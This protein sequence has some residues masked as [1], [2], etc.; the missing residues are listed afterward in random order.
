MTRAPRGLIVQGVA[1]LLALALLTLAGPRP[2][3][4]GHALTALDPVEVYIDGFGD[5]R[6][7]AVDPAG[8]VFVSDR[9]AGRVTRIAPDRTKTILVSGLERPIGLAFDLSGR[10][11]IA[12]EREARV[13]RLEPGGALTPLVTGIKQPR[14]LAVREDGTLYIAARR[15]TRGTDPEPTRELRRPPVPLGVP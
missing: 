9:A 12:E 7:I 5:L 4:A 14:W 1:P 10:L 8:N 11:L 13:V 6:G 15:L 3:Q 2:A